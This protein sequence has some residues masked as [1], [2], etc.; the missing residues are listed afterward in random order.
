M[1][2]QRLILIVDDDYDFLEINRHILEK[3]GFR[4]ATASSPAQA[5]ERIAAETP[6]LVITDL[7]MSEVDSGFSL[8]R[9][10]RDDPRTAAVPI[11]MSTSVTTALGLDFTPRSAADLASMK[12]DAYFDK[13]LDPAALVAKVRELLGTAP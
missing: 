4:V 10:L 11:I 7:M 13:P 5:M 12:V 1:A 9:G 8:S 2:E 3:A 6:D